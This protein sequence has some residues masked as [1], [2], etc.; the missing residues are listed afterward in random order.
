MNLLPGEYSYE[1]FDPSLALT[2]PCA[3]LLVGHTKYKLVENLEEKKGYEVDYP[4]KALVEGVYYDFNRAGEDKD[5][6][7]IYLAVGIIDEEGAKKGDIQTKTDASTGESH[8]YAITNLNYRESVAIQVLNAMITHIPNPIGYTTAT[9]K[10]LISKAFE[11]AVEFTNQ[12]LSLRVENA[13]VDPETGQIVPD[14]TD[15]VSALNSI[16]T[17]LADINNTENGVKHALDGTTAAGVASKVATVADR[18]TTTNTNIASVG[19]SVGVIGTKVET[20]D[21]NIVNAI[22][23]ISIPDVS[24]QLR[25]ISED[26]DTANSKLDNIKTVVDD[27][28]TKVTPTTTTS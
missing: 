27:I 2:T 26:V 17:K 19:T 1:P 3:V 13:E 7:E 23:N 15:I 18:L 16:M 6:N 28:D 14:S 20:G 24:D 12:A 25:G 22:N 5:G 8:Y 21:S 9:I 11:F 10:L 4:Y